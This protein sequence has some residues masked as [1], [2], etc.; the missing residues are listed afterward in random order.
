MAITANNTAV[1]LQDAQIP[2]GYTKPTITRIAPGNANYHIRKTISVDKTTVDTTTATATLT[3]IVAN[4]NTQIGT[5]VSTAFN[6]TPNVVWQANLVDIS[7]TADASASEAQTSDFYLGVNVTY[8]C[9]VDI[10]LTTDG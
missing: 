6:A 10:Y 8:E 3:A 7:S 9:V 2:A 5:L 4:L 1:D